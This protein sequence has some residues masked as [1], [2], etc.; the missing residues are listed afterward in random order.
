[1]QARMILTLCDRIPNFDCNSIRQALVVGERNV[2]IAGAACGASC[3]YA[4]CARLIDLEQLP[5]T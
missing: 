3:E 4:Q 2:E 5:W 1:M